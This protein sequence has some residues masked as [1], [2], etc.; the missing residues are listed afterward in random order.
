MSDLSATLAPAVTAAT[1]L[2]IDYD[3]RL[4]LFSGR[5]NPELSHKIAD[6]LGAMVTPEAYFLDASNKLIYHGRIDNSRN[7]DNIETTDLRNAIDAAL[8]G[9]AIEKTEAK[10]FGC[11][12]KRA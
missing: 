3:K 1:S 7:G 4:M 10:A 5:A 9:K 11:T 2:P 8:A 12:I 6:K